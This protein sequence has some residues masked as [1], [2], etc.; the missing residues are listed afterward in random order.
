MSANK[1]FSSNIPDSLVKTFKEIDDKSLA[2]TRKRL[3]EEQKESEDI[4]K[5]YD[6]NYFQ[7]RKDLLILTGTIFGS[8]IA[9]ASG[10]TPNVIFIAGELF[11]FLSII[12][13]FVILQTYLKAK[14]WNY[15]FTSKYSLESY[16]IMTKNKIEEFELNTTKDLIK[17]YEKILKKNQSGILYFLLKII[18]LDK[19]PM[20]FNLTLITGIFIILV[21]IAPFAGNIENYISEV[22]VCLFNCD[23]H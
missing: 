11:L 5:S 3:D 13:G 2:Q 8:S 10:R 17:D 6:D 14:E 1:S 22:F 16:L 7:L 12:S 15:A 18:P 9:L 20:I 23:T 21:S 4:L 19:W